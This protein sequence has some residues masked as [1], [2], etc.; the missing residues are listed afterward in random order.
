MASDAADGREFNDIIVEYNTGYMPDKPLKV[1]GGQH[2]ISAISSAWKKSNRYHGFRVYFELDKK[3]RTEVALI[4]NTNIAVSNDTFDRMLEETVFG[5]A[6]RKWCQAVGFLAD[7]E[8]FPDVGARSERITVKRAR[9]FITNYY[10]GSTRGAELKTDELDRTVYEPYLVKSGVL[11]DSEYEEIMH[12]VNILEDD[13]LLRA[14]KEFL[15]LHKVQYQAVISEKTSVPNRKAYRSK[16]FVESV[17]CAWS[18]VSTWTK[19][20]LYF[21]PQ[22]FGPQAVQDYYNH[23]LNVLKIISSFLKPPARFLIR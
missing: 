8:D 16:A 18:Y 23:T 13:S 1:W 4:S 10:L 21:S 19:L 15:A 11:I 5:D 17:L 20:N 9:S 6:L 22:L 14:G 3:Q 12:E 2:R 7:G